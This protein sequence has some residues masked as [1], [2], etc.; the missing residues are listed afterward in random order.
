MCSSVTLACNTV[1]SYIYRD[2]FLYA[3]DA[4]VDGYE[5]LQSGIASPTATD[6]A[7]HP[8]ESDTPVMVENAAYSS[9]PGEPTAGVTVENAAYVSSSL[10]ASAMV[11]NAACTSDFG[12]PTVMVENAAYV[13]SSSKPA[14]VEGLGEGN[15][16]AMVM[17]NAVM[18]ATA[19][20]TSMESGTDVVVAKLS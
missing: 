8:T 20:S 4:V 6:A 14:V 2:A 18:A 1:K 15:I 3:G 19:T 5:I 13:F 12:V 10:D 11:E 16:A 17:K 7:A 9:N